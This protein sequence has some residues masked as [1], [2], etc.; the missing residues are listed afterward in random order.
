MRDPSR[1]RGHVHGGPL[2]M[3]A[4]LAGIPRIHVSFPRKDGDGDVEAPPGT[5]TVDWGERRIDIFHNFRLLPRISIIFPVE[6]E[7]D[8]TEMAD[9]SVLSDESL[10]RLL[11]EESGSTSPEGVLE[12]PPVS[13]EPQVVAEGIVDEMEVARSIVN[14]DGLRDVVLPSAPAAEEERPPPE[15][16]E[17]PIPR[18]AV[19]LIEGVK[20]PRTRAISHNLC[21]GL[22]ENG[23]SVTYVSTSLVVKDIILEMHSRNYRIARFLPDRQLLCVPV[24]PIIEDK[25]T[26]DGLLEKLME[27]PQLQTTDA[28]MVD[29]LSD[30]LEDFDD[31]ICMR[32]L[33]YLRVLSGMG[34]TIFLCVDDGQKGILS[35]R[36]AS[37]LH[38][39]LSL[40]GDE[41]HVQVK[42]YSTPR[43]GAKNV[44]H[45][46]VDPVI[47]LVSHPRLSDRRG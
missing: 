27:S 26:K 25:G 24:Y 13:D 6:T 40:D 39:A 5:K 42:R 17:M 45:F 37:D 21:Y 16:E 9:I 3:L 18:G 33:E 2:V 1:K 35:L 10:E 34:K 44:L 41:H 23:Y 38:F 14:A 19:V 36:L 15:A 4:V 20:G 47:G 22:L 12:D 11:R 31:M 32:L 8:P 7:D 43:S 30:F 29:T 46:K 28:I